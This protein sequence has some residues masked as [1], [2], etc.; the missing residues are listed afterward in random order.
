L[1]VRLT[2]E[3][4]AKGAVEKVEVDITTVI[5]GGR[6]MAADRLSQAETVGRGTVLR[7]EPA[8]IGAADRLWLTIGAVSPDVCL[9]AH[10]AWRF[11]EIEPQWDRLVLRSFAGRHPFQEGPLAA[12]GAP[13]DLIA[14]RT[15]SKRL[16]IGVAFLCGAPPGIGALPADPDIAIEL[17]DPVLGRKLVQRYG[18]NA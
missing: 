5:A 16:G 13:R 3:G 17:E 7:A 15:G 6:Q 2:F 10:H 4:A 9:I 18:I 11:E 14:T 12:L 8:L 1:T